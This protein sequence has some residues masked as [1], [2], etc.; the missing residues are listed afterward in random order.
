LTV[1]INTAMPEVLAAV[2]LAPGTV[3]TI[4]HYRSG[5]EHFVQ[6]GPALI[7]FLESQGLVLDDVDERNRLA[8]QLF[9]VAS[10]SFLVV[11]EGAVESLD[12]HVRVQAVIQRGT[13][14]SSPTIIAWKEG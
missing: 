1:N 8:S 9:T 13:G 10:Q 7:S 2:G 11:S 4:V 3:Q 14:G 6:T 12:V 5:A